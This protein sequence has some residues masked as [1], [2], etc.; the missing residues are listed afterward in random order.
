MTAAHK[1]IPERTVII[2]CGNRVVFLSAS[3]YG[4]QN[5]LLEGQHGFI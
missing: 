5:N 4:V 2:S 3:R 1:N